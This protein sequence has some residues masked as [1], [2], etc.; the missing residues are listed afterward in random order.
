MTAAGGPRD[1]VLHVHAVV[2][3]GDD[4]RDLWVHDGVVRVEP[5]AGAETVA[6][7][8]FLLPGLVDAHCHVGLS[9]TGPVTDR[10]EQAAQAEAD[11]DAGVLLLRDAGSPVD[12]SWLQQRNDMPRLIRA[13]RHLA[14][15]R[16]YIPS[17]AVELEPEQLPDAVTEEARR[18]DGWVKL[19]GDWIDRQVGDL[20]PEWP[21]DTLAEAVGRAHAEGA[22]VAVHTFGEEALPDL[23][24]AGVDSIEHGT[25]LTADLV[26][27]VAR[28]G[29]A[30]VPT[31]INTDN[32]PS[33]ADGASRY[34]TFAARMRRLHA[35]SRERVRAAYDAGVRIYAGSDAGGSLPHGLVAKE[36]QALHAAGLSAVDALA[37]G[38]WGARSWLGLPGLADGAPADFTVYAED[39][40]VDLRVLDAPTRIVLRGRV[41]R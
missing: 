15:T 36:I 13:G 31:L 30:L 10:G 12:T 21:A 6:P 22:R 19:V 7:Q 29:I 17:V 26:D 32:L 39:P 38:S 5:I 11:R 35:C 41:I 23:I 27:E 14:R 24:A 8:G 9:T 3:P 33:I 1:P 18:G 28:R 16:R 4:P 34:P 37:A 20:A 40:R 25:G 2:L